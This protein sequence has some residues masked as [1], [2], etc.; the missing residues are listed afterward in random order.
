MEVRQ[1]LPIMLRTLQRIDVSD[2]HEA[3][4][5]EAPG[6][7]AEIDAVL[8]RYGRPDSRFRRV[9]GEA[10]RIELALSQ[11]A[12]TASGTAT[13]EC[14]LLD[15][16]MIV[17]YRLRLISYALAKLLV[18]VPNV[19]LVN[20]IVGKTLVPELLQREWCP[21]RLEAVTADMLGGGAAA[22][23]SGLAEASKLLGEPGASRQAALAVAEYFC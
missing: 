21:E 22:Q 3:V 20:L 1:L 18:R 13:L 5:V 17:G 19:A 6:M 2:I 15:V 7:G 14:A 12:W 9:K 16:P 8:S 11:M 23:R 10:R 4:L